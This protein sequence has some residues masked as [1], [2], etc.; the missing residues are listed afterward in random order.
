MMKKKMHTP[1]GLQ[2]VQSRACVKQAL[3]ASGRKYD[4]LPDEHEADFKVYPQDGG[5]PFNV[6]AFGRCFVWAKKRNDNLRHAFCDQPDSVNREV[7]MFPHD[8]F[9]D[10]FI[11]GKVGRNA[12]PK[13]WGPGYRSWPILHGTVREVLAPYR[14][15]PPKP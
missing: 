15:Y 7:Y 11:Q 2:K 1:R 12:H 14:I 13:K 3:D 4:L 10:L 9:L 6:R 8:E 5:A